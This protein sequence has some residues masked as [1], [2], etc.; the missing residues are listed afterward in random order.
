[1]WRKLLALEAKPIDGAPAPGLAVTDE[2][3]APLAV[4]VCLLLL[5]AF[6][7]ATVFV[8]HAWALQAFQIGIFALVAVYLLAGIRNKRE[9]LAAG[10]T[11]WLVYLIPLW[12]VLQILTHTTASTMETRQAVLKWGA[13]AGVFFLSQV[14]GRTRTARRTVLSSFLIFATAMAILCLMQLFT[15]QGKVLWLFP[16]GYPDVFGTFQYANNYVQ[17]VEL[18]LPIALWRAMKEGWHSWRYL[19]AAG[20]LYASAIASASRAGTVLCTVEMVA[21]LLIGLV[22]LRAPETGLP[23]RS[24]VAVLA[25][26]PLLAAAFTVAVGWERILVRFQQDDPYATRREFFV[27]A[28]DMTKQHP[29]IGYGL[30]TFPDVYQRY[31]IKD[32]PFYANHAHNDWAEFAA[33]GG[34]PF[35]LLVLIPFLAVLRAAVRNGWALGLIAVMLHACM[36]YPFPRP[37]VSGWIYLLLGLLCMAK[38]TTDDHNSSVAMPQAAKLDPQSAA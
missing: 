8:R 1:M 33:D 13:L 27:A 28:M 14:V 10:V 12:G 6:T 3:S 19:L 29:L 38:A 36:D 5:L 24:T 23:S 30:G 7:T 25:A 35:L 16:S 21:V 31:A 32:F 2:R 34:I 17:F 11:P 37:A 4:G 18:A 9:Q 22:K 20:I 26:I 15:S